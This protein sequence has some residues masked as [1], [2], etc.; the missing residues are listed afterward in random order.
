MNTKAFSGQSYVAG[1]ILFSVIVALGFLMVVS[2]ADDYG[3][4]D[5]VDQKF[6]DNYDKLNENTVRINDMFSAASSKEGLGLLDTA[7][8]L[9]SSTFSIISLIFGSLAT[10][11]SQVLSIGEDVGIPTSVSSVVLVA[12]LALLTAAIVFLI[13]NAINK[14]ER[15]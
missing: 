12:F 10:V 9:L 13:I 6:S 5:I 8:I 11:G 2:M 15:L 3:N 1:L 7:D 4:D 14:T